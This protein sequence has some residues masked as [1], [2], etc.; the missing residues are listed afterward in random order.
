MYIGHCW[1]E[2][3]IYAYLIFAKLDPFFLEM[4]CHSNLLVLGNLRSISCKRK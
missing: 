2:L 3:A 1:F 4:T